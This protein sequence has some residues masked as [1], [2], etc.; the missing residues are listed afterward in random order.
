MVESHEV[1]GKGY[2]NTENNQIVFIGAIFTSTY[3]KSN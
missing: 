3:H 1:V 2:I